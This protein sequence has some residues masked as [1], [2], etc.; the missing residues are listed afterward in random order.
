[1]EIECFN[2]QKIARLKGKIENISTET[3]NK[4][5]ALGHEKRLQVYKLLKEEPCC[6]CDLAHVF[7]APVSTVSQYLKV[8]K[9][10]GLVSS[11][12]DGK[13]L[14]YSAKESD[15]SDFL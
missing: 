11:K 2:E 15:F 12:N 9:N 10:A 13:F 14:I 3:I 1:M 5:K 7:G 6:V 8:L 4:F